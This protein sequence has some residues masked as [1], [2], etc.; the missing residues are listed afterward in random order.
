[1]TRKSQNIS[2]IFIRLK[3]VLKMVIQQNSTHQCVYEIMVF[4]MPMY[5]TFYFLFIT[6]EY[7]YQ[8]ATSSGTKVR[9]IVTKGK[10]AT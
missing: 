4:C 10:V 6:S 9:T 3:Y 7:M 8:W 1:M 2:S 5:D